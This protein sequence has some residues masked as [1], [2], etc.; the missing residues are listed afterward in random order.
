MRVKLSVQEG[1]HQG[2]EFEF[3][4]HDSFIVGRSTR[5]QFRLPLKDSSL[6]RVHFMVEINPPQCRLTDLGST[7]GTKVNGRK[8]SAV[9]LGDGDVI[10]AGLTILRFSVT[11]EEDATIAL[12]EVVV[13][14]PEK[15]IPGGGDPTSPQSGGGIVTPS[16]RSEP[17]SPAR[18]AAS[19]APVP[20][21][22]VPE[23]NLSALRRSAETT[24]STC[25]ACSASL[26]AFSTDDSVRP[27][28]EK[29]PQ[30]C[31]AC[32]AR[33]REFPQPVIGYEAIRELGRGGMG[34][35]YLAYD[36]SADQLVALKTIKPSIASDFVQ[37]E[38]FLREARI[39]HALDH[40]NIVPY[41]AMGETNELLFF[42]MQYVRGSDASRIRD[43]HAGEFPIGRAVGWICQL[44][45]A[46]DYAHVKGFVHRDIKPSNLLVEQEGGRETVHLADFGLARVYQTSTLSGLT[47][48]GDMGGTIPFMA[49]EQIIHLREAKPPVDL[50]AAAAS[51]YSLLTGQFIHD[52]PRGLDKQIVMVLQDAPVPIRSRR[53]DIPKGLADVIHRSLAK[54][55]EHRFADAKD[56]RRALLKFC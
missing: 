20:S 54:E 15:R 44:L 37:R 48:K 28:T 26:P 21:T 23:V 31:P 27:S 53:P 8:V 52:L 39:L 35:V 47:M 34:V 25:S 5:A 10:A 24:A 3:R 49:P 11:E 51:L 56:M 38:R 41:L 19:S 46:L 13:S 40:P 7:N 42:A 45:Q 12:D 17:R 55:P 6:S 50:Y 16:Q 2:R 14:P 22:I 1:P 32:A 4:E 30:I 29:M 33:A 9:D 18:A 36:T 43:K